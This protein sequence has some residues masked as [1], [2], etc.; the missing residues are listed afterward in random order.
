VRQTGRQT[1]GRT[2][3]QTE[4]LYDRVP[5]AAPT[6]SREM[7]VPVPGKDGMFKMMENSFDALPKF[8]WYEIFSVCG[9]STAIMSYVVFVLLIF[10]TTQSENQSNETVVYIS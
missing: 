4:E 2:D 3:G 6:T 1:D 7:I 8:D 9:A 10:I 5:V